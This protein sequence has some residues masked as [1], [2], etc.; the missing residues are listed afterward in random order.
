MK[1]VYLLES[2]ATLWGGVKIALAGANLMTARG[3]EMIVLS[4]TQPPD[5]IEQDYEHR[6]VPSFQPDQIPD[7]DL[8]VAF[9]WQSVP[10]V[11][12]CENAIPVHF[13]QGFEGCMRQNLSVW[14]TIDQVYRIPVPRIA[15]SKHLTEML[16]D[17]FDIEC[18]EIPN[19][20]A[21][22]WTVM[23]SRSRVMC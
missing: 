2:T 7:A 9:E 15:I 6:V 23:V 19:M 21:S 1:I 11:A 3:H 20:V 12:S 10:V 18:L 16:S 4:L 14:Q 17:R 5:W 8:V 22:S 13:V